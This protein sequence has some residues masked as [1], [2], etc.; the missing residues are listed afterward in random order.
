MVRLT[1]GNLITVTGL[2]VFGILIAKWILNQVPVPGLS[3][4]VN[5]V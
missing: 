4:V 2:A 5:S 3:D 1:I